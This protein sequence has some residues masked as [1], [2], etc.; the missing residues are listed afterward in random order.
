[1]RLYGTEVQSARY[2]SGNKSDMPPL[3][4]VKQRSEYKYS[5]TYFLYKINIWESIY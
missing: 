4:I 3:S 5:Y 1:M 2:Y